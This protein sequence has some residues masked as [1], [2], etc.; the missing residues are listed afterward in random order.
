MEDN[1]TG[2]LREFLSQSREEEL[3]RKLIKDVTGEKLDFWE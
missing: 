3:R 1:N 2:R